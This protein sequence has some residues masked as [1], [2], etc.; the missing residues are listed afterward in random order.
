PDHSLLHSFPTRRS[1]DLYG[2]GQCIAD[3]YAIGCGF[4]AGF[5][6]SGAAVVCPYGCTTSTNTILGYVGAARLQYFWASTNGPG[7]YYSYSDRKSTR[8]NSSHDQISY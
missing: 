7:A 4:L 5:L 2:G 3:G 6:A 1:S 8:L